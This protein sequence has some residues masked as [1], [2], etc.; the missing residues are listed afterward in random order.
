[1]GYILPVNNYKYEQYIRQDIAQKIRPVKSQ[2]VF[3]PAVISNTYERFDQPY[4]AH[5]KEASKRRMEDAEKLIA[6]LTGKGR[7]FNKLV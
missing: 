1:M 5:N 3:A 2:K 7:Q 4:S 6:E